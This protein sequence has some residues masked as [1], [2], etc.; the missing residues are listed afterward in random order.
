MPTDNI[1]G[2]DRHS[3]SLI[4]QRTL[5]SYNQLNTTEGC[6]QSMTRFQFLRT[7]P[8][9]KGSFLE[10]PAINIDS[11]VLEQRGRARVTHGYCNI[12]RRHL[13][14]LIRPKLSVS[15]DVHA[16]IFN[17]STLS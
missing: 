3:Q 14:G 17:Y 5:L 2:H 7:L 11:I 16:T 1:P 8:L 12:F 15:L 10:K 4:S 13:K 6:E 9:L